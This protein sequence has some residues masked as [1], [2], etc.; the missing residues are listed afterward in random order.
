M[1]VSGS[2][3]IVKLTKENKYQYFWQELE[4]SQTSV[5]FGVLACANAK[6]LLTTN[7]GE[8]NENSY[9][10]TIGESNGQETSIYRYGGDDD[11][12]HVMSTPGI[13]DEACNDE[14]RFKWMWASWTQGL[15]QLGEGNIVGQKT[16]IERRSEVITCNRS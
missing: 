1:F 11:D 2:S 3:T 4:P 15:V 7:K 5:V 9:E 16:V 10:I 8:L 12:K 14:Y 13:L 6:V